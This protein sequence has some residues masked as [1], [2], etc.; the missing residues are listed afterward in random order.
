[1]PPSTHTQTDP[2]A[3]STAARRRDTCERD[4]GGR[5]WRKRSQP[6]DGGWRDH[7][8]VDYRR[9]DHCSERWCNWLT[10]GRARRRRLGAP[11]LRKDD[12]AAAP[13]RGVHAPARR[14]SVPGPQD[15]YP[16]QPH[17]PERRRRHSRDH[18]IRRRD[19]SVPG[20]D[21]YA[22]ARVQTRLDRMWRAA[23]GSP[24]LMQPEA[25]R[26]A[27]PRQGDR[28]CPDLAMSAVY[29]ARQAVPVT[30]PVAAFDAPLMC[31]CES[32]VDSWRIAGRGPA[33]RELGD[34]SETK[35]LVGSCRR[36]ERCHA[37]PRAVR[38]RP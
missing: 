18:R 15:Q 22:G 13:D 21:G 14:P 24:T 11:T 19:P 32:A 3:A 31:R 16:V 33:I 20:L 9:V 1:M 28:E 27:G 30:Y 38:A 35:A 26:H 29:S 36:R 5:M 23:A 34:E 12:G 37:E 8:W 4:P 10:L 17:L 2:L 7:G 25:E 6:D